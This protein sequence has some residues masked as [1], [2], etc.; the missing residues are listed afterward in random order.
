MNVQQLRHCHRGLGAAP[1]NAIWP[2]AKL[3]IK[4]KYGVG[5]YNYD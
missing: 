5:L 4:E 3:A 2:L 1:R